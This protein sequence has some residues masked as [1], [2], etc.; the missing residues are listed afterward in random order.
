MLGL[1]VGNMFCRPSSPLEHIRIQHP[2]PALVGLLE[3]LPARRR[4]G[5]VKGFYRQ[6]SPQRKQTRVG[7]CCMA[8]NVDCTPTRWP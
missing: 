4:K 7:S 1:C 3:G 5:P 8:A 6:R 2:G